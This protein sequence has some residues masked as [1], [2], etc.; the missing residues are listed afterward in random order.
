[1][2]VI[3]VGA[4]IGGLTLALSLHARGV[5]PLLLD[6]VPALE[7][8][9]AGVQLGP[10][11]TRLLFA[12]GLEQALRAVATQPASADV[13]DGSNGTPLF[14]MPLGAEAEARWGAPY[15]QVH[16]ADLQSVLLE[17]VQSRNAAELRLGTAVTGLAMGGVALAGG[18]PL[19]ADVV[20]GA[21]G[22]RSI[23]RQAICPA[24]P[25]RMLGETAWRALIPIQPQDAPSAVVWTCPRRHLVA[26]PVS[27][28][29]FLNLVAVTPGD[30]GDTSWSTPADPADLRRAFSDAAPEVRALLARVESIS[31]WPLAD[32]A[33]LPRWSSGNAVVMGDAAHATAPYLAQGAAMAIEDAEALARHMT[34]P[35]DL[36]ERLR[37][38]EAERRPRTARVQAA[39]RRNGTI[40]HLPSP[41]TALGFGLASFSDRLGGR[42][43]A[44]RLD[45]LYGYRPPA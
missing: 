42:S 36:T 5:R 18:E 4:G 44:A 20:I 7:A 29:A 12:L 24:S 14:S 23:V 45:W 39:S 9:G 28:G 38:F 27:G 10:N 6:R 19:P 34:G 43:P 3:G 25:P 30:R 35:G 15:L 2:R 1:M 21:D 17:A 26:Y 8:A 37:G 32:L 22:V 16:R 40:F 33:R 11:A 13:R 41:I 31:R